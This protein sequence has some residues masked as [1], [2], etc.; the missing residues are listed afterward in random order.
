MERDSELADVPKSAQPGHESPINRF[1]K[2]VSEGSLYDP[3]TFTNFDLSIIATALG[4]IGL[5]FDLD[6]PE[7]NRPSTF[8]LPIVTTVEISETDKTFAA[9]A[10]FTAKPEPI[11][12]AKQLIDVSRWLEFRCAR[13]QQHKVIF[14]LNIEPIKAAHGVRPANKEL[15]FYS[16]VKIGQFPAHA[17]LVAGRLRAVS[18]IAARIDAVELRR[19]AGLISNDVAIGAFVYLRR[20]FERII[21]GAWKRAIESGQKLPD[22]TKMRMAE[23]VTALKAHLPEVV[24]R[25]AKAYGI[26]SQGLHELSEEQCAKV[27]PVLEGSS[28]A[29]LEDIHAQ[30]EKQRRDKLLAASLDE[31]AASLKLPKS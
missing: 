8:V 30:A 10:A 27:Y 4:Q 16:C 23:K 17:E 20:V 11:T 22:A 7:C 13:H 25:H 14:I 28:I 24:T 12:K 18:K 26:L 31:F 19:A 15:S 21:E 29:M 3:Q 2:L 9:L 6:C 5:R 1:S